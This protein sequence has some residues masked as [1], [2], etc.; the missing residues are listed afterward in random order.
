[1]N[2]LVAEPPAGLAAAVA[3]GGSR[4]ADGSQPQLVEAAHAAYV[5][6]LNAVL[7]A[8]AAPLLAGGIIALAL[9]RERDIHHAAPAAESA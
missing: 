5:A 1:L 4:A 7:L 6:G 9:V 8:G 2:E 3:A